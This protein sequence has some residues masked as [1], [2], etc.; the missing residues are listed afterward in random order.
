MQESLTEQST[1]VTPVLVYMTVI[2]RIAN[3]GRVTVLCGWDEQCK[4]WQTDDEMDQLLAEFGIQFL[5]GLACGCF[6]R[7]NMF[8]ESANP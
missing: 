7:K 2:K 4:K 1:G 8:L 5:T 3:T 6:A